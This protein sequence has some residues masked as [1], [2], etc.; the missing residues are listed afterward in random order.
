MM[1]RGRAHSSDT[2]GVAVSCRLVES[3]FPVLNTIHSTA[4]ADHYLGGTLSVRDPN[5]YPY[6]YGRIR[7]VCVYARRALSDEWPAA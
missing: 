4:Y 6:R 2:P 3:C 1:Y 7:K 5:P